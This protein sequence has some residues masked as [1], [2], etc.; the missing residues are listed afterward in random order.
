M[1]II[2]IICACAALYNMTIGVADDVEDE[3]DLYGEVEMP[4]VRQQAAGAGAVV[5]R[6]IVERHFI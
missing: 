4:P 1:T 3:E 2:A 6:G 5:R